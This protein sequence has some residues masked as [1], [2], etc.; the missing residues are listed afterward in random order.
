M[1]AAHAGWRGL[2]G[3]VLE[4]TL[5][6]MGAAAGDVL[7]WLGPTIRTRPHS[8]WAA[9]CGEQFLEA[10]PAADVSATDALFSPG[11]NSGHYFAD[12]Y[13]WP[14]CVWPQPV[15]RVFGGGSA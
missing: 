1:A 13:A 6:A 14:G 4:S 9:K 2:L 3:G 15:R 11:G 5:A 12:L 7:A 8:R 10:A